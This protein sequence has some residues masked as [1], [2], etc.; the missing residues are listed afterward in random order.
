MNKPLLALL[1][2]SSIFSAYAGNL[3]DN[4]SFELQEK[5]PGL[6][7]ETISFYGWE[8]YGWQ[9][10]GKQQN[11]GANG[12]K[13]LQTKKTRSYAKWLTPGTY[14]LS[15]Y[16][17]SDEKAQVD[18][19]LQTN[20]RPS[21]TIASKKFLLD[22]QWKRYHVQVK[23]TVAGRY[24]LLL[25][26]LDNK[27]FD[28]DAVQLE[29]GALSEYQPK[30][31]IEGTVRIPGNFNRIYHS[32]QTL[33]F[34]VTLF[35]MSEKTVK[36]KYKIIIQDVFFN[37][38]DV[39]N[40]EAELMPNE[41][42]TF[43]NDYSIKENGVFRILLNID[44]NQYISGATYAV[45]PK[46][47]NPD[48]FDQGMPYFGFDG[49][50][51]D[52][53]IQMAKILGAKWWRSCGM[54][55]NTDI[56]AWGRV[57]PQ[58]NKFVWRDDLIQKLIDNKFNILSTFLF[59]P[60]WAAQA[61]A[62]ANDTEK[63]RFRPKDFN[64]WANFVENYTTHNK[65]KIACY[66][67][68]NE[69]SGSFFNGGT[70][71]EFVKFHKIAEG[72]IRKNDPNAKIMG[73]ANSLSAGSKSWFDAFVNGGGLENI[74]YYDKHYA[75]NN[76]EKNIIE[77]AGVKIWQSEYN[78][79]SVSIH[80]ASEFGPHEKDKA[81][82]RM[83]LAAIRVIDELGQGR[84]G[85][86]YYYLS[87]NY[88]MGMSRQDF[89]D[90]PIRDFD[91]GPTAFVAP[92]AVIANKLY[93]TDTSGLIKTPPGITGYL[94]TNRDNQDCIVALYAPYNERDIKLA[95]KEK[96]PAAANVTNLS[97][98]AA[99][100]QENTYS[101]NIPLFISFPAGEK[102]KVISAIAASKSIGVMPVT[103]RKKFTAMNRTIPE[104]LRNVPLYACSMI[105]SEM[106]YFIFE[107]GDTAY[108][109]IWNE[110]PT[111]SLKITLPESVS[112][113][114]AIADIYG[115]N[116]SRK[117]LNFKL[118]IPHI[119][120]FTG[121]AQQ[122]KKALDDARIEGLHSVSIGN[123][124][125]SRGHL[126]VEI[127][128]NTLKN[129]SGV[130]KINPLTNNIKFKQET[131]AFEDIEPKQILFQEVTGGTSTYDEVIDAGG[132]KIINIPVE[133]FTGGNVQLN[134]EALTSDK[135]TSVRQTTIKVWSATKSQKEKRIDGDLSDWSLIDGIDIDKPYLGKWEGKEDV[136]G[137]AYAAWDQQNLYI[138]IIV[139]DNL[140][141]RNYSAAAMWNGDCV[142]L[143][144]N[145]CPELP[146]PLSPEITDRFFQVLLGPATN[147]G[148]SKPETFVL[149]TGQFFKANTLTMASSLQKDGYIIE[150]KIPFSSFQFM[151]GVIKPFDALG[152][153]VVI[154]DNDLDRSSLGNVRVKGG[155]KSIVG[156][157]GGADNY[158]NVSKYGSLVLIK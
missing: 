75:V 51:C 96:L 152:C 155:R 129:I 139:K 122:L 112:D 6:T 60:I 31:N 136:H 102:D 69:A 16:L 71:E 44:N 105:Y 9:G 17:K 33:P 70:P 140:V 128:N 62:S 47:R 120:K 22:N 63:W 29:S 125:F 66:E 72:I 40:F 106:P 80:P 23:V 117:D 8:G 84:I 79:S 54:N 39:K 95:F 76:E 145:P 58:K 118:P 7:G 85:V 137:K 110:K 20:N 158:K 67:I 78:P 64:D 119:I 59:T 53:N 81:I 82:L 151:G 15:A 2:F 132:T 115:E 156:W 46:P 89:D 21:H 35:N 24:Y 107:K 41:I 121:Q 147:N 93:H 133:E 12:R 92:L 32:G 56:S 28:L 73:G 154:N 57:E 144:F 150:L 3:L 42:K 68:W 134:I 38:V 108:A 30:N 148:I 4:S 114:V 34:S 86:S 109:I 27:I 5:I 104:Y 74:D 50:I 91:G 10:T 123:P 111:E 99:T 77:K 83:N 124:R 1:I 157:C 88:V 126:S 87:N 19:S 90:I 149:R 116:Y 127:K 138:A 13:S 37:N 49:T 130:L 43:K 103:F 52:E 97:G 48:S 98:N 61:P 135:K 94:F 113:K 131:V 101:L 142:E 25:Q 45:V 55:D 14:T 65:N 18:L 26:T 143:F 100:H 153:D 141:G 11:G 146:Y 36:T